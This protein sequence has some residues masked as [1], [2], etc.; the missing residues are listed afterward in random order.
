MIL[1]A[2]VVV[3][4]VCGGHSRSMVGRQAPAL[5][6]TQNGKAVDLSQWRGEYVLLS[7]WSAVNAPS[8][9]DINVYTAW[10]RSHPQS[11]IKLVGVNL[12]PSDNLFKSIVASDR[13]SADEQYTI[14]ADKLQ[15]AERNYGLERG[16][17]SVLIGPDGKIVSQ[18]PTEGE[19]DYY[20]GSGS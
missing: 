19:L 20:A 7:F 6:L 13:L 3:C 4:L 11:G 16:L 10:E 14:P 12:D 17:G 9:R 18:N 15:D 1:L 5:E 8:R 2:G